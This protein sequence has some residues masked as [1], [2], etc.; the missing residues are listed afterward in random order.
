MLF[1]CIDVAHKSS[2]CVTL[3]VSKVNSHP[4]LIRSC[5]V[6]IAVFVSTDEIRSDKCDKTRLALMV[7]A[8]LLAVCLI[9]NGITS[10]LLTKKLQCKTRNYYSGFRLV[11]LP[12]R[13]GWSIVRIF[14]YVV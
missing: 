10:T 12:K 5:V 11:T 9:I 2:H 7:S 6:T 1:F 8:V 3:S 13:G 14:P 4:K